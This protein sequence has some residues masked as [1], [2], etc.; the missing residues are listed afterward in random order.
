MTLPGTSEYDS[1]ASIEPQ[2][3]YRRYAEAR[4]R[5]S[6]K[7][8]SRAQGANPVAEARQQAE[9]AVASAAVQAVKGRPENYRVDVGQV[10]DALLLTN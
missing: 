10:R 5:S 6:E 8:A 4:R 3:Q 7:R 2:R 1:K 9:R